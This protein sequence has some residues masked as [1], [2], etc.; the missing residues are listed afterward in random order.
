[1]SIT[2]AR[3]SSSTIWNIVKIILALLLVGFVLSRTD[4]NQL[5]SLLAHIS[6]PWLVGYII[7]FLSL[8]VLKAV[9]YYYLNGEGVSFPSVLNVVVMQNVI[10]NYFASTAGIASYLV[11]FRA[12]HG[13]KVGRSAVI[14]I[15][16]K[17][18]DLI[19]IWVA[20]CVSSLLVW[21]TIDIF[22]NFVLAVAAG[23]GLVLLIFFLTVLFRQKFVLLLGK[24]LKTL[25]LSQL[26]FIQKGMNTLDALSETESDMVARMLVKAFG[27][28]T[29][30]FLLSIAWIYASFQAFN[31]QQD[32]R[33]IVFVSTLMQMVSYVPIQIFGGL[34]VSEAG[35]LY[36]WTPFPVMQA[37]LASVLIGNRI[38]FYLVNLL[39]LL[40][41]P[42]YTLFLRPKDD[43]SS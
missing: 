22:H 12:E 9:Q 6:I 18:G 36:F 8:T 28:S 39:P 13:V 25:R 21:Q 29:I 26:S 20:L 40:Y 16:T 7:L 33:D 2:P 24:V 38:I 32:L 19:I 42:I 30:Y 23:I 15:L 43:P 31:F 14:F 3:K 1:M 17:I 4:L 11:L 37:E 27:L 34:G 35:T 41:L 10:T 5:R